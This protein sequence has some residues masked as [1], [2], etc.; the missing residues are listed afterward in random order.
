MENTT[1]L[2]MISFFVMKKDLLFHLCVSLLFINRSKRLRYEHSF[3]DLSHTHAPLLHEDGVNIKG[4]Q[5]RLGHAD[6]DTT[7]N[8]YC[9][10]TNSLENDSIDKLNKKFHNH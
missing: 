10:I 7:M 5:D 3:H 9:H 2:Y 6:I 8:I 1:T 4:I